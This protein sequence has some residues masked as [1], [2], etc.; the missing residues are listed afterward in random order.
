M[1]RL[2]CKAS[3]LVG[4]IQVSR[5]PKITLCKHALLFDYD[6]WYCLPSY[7]NTMLHSGKRRPSA[8]HDYSLFSK[9]NNAAC[10]LACQILFCYPR[11]VAHLVC[12]YPADG[13]WVDRISISW[14]PACNHHSISMN[15]GMFTSR[16]FRLMKVFQLCSLHLLSSYK[17]TAMANWRNTYAYVYL[18]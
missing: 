16:E 15:L 10:L 9:L 8:C 7:I 12:Y 1:V 6:V 18:E 3:F 14:L 4:T 13:L 5:V 2:T 11:G 17:L